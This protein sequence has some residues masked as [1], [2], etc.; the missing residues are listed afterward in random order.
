M[1]YAVRV[2]TGHNSTRHTARY[3]T[4]NSATNVFSR[5]WIDPGSLVPVFLNFQE[6]GRSYGVGSGILLPK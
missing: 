6:L 2:V 3:T 1:Q 4:H 5:G